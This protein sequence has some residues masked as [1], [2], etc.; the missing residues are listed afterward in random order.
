MVARS[1]EVGFAEEVAF[2]EEVVFAEEVAFVDVL[3]DSVML[4]SSNEGSYN[5]Q[6]QGYK[7]R[8]AV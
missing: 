1:E 3:L 2:A 6:S 4:L 7:H 5:Q 8:E